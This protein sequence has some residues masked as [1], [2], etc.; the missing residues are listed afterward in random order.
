MKV[1]EI[2]TP[3]TPHSRC[4]AVALQIASN[5]A[6]LWHDLAVNTYLQGH[7]MERDK[8]ADEA[9]VKSLMDRSLA[10][11]RKS[12]ALEPTS[13]KIWNSLGLVA[14]HKGRESWMGRGWGLGHFICRHNDFVGLIIKN[15]LYFSLLIFW[16]YV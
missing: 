11:L 9:A 14:S 10:A 1:V 13:G 2:S 15:K 3:S 5:D 12:L 16:S 8:G 6:S 7:V 4:Y